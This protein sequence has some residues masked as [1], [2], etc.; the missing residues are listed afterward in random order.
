M[1]HKLALVAV[2]GLTL[3]AVCLGAGGALEGHDL[4]EGL[5]RFSI[6]NDGPR[7]EAMA[8]GDTITSRDMNWD[9]SDH[10]ILT[11]PG[12][13]TYTP[14][15]DDRMHVSGDARLVSH[16]RVRDGRVELDCHGWNEGDNLTITLPGREFN[17]FSIAGSGHLALQKLNQDRIRLSIAGSGSIVADGKVQNAEVHIGGS[18]DVNISQVNTA[19]VKVDIRGSGNTDIAPTDEADIHISGSGD[20]NLH[21]NPRKLETRIRGSGRIH[22]VGA[23]G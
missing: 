5:G 15:T 21:T 6:F 18:G 8:G 19:V 16:V 9:G 23:G 12:H 1:V 2:A 4:G 13:A 14:G 7:C 10:V 11:A 3:S 20:V 22:N 17:K